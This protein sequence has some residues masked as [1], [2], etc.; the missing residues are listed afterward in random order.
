V[1][2]DSGSRCALCGATHKDRPLD[3][4]HIKPKSKGGKN[5]YEN[6]QVLCA[7]CNRS[8]GNKDDT[9]FRNAKSHPGQDCPFCYE[10]SKGRLEEELD[11]VFAI[12][13]GFPVSDGHLLIILKRHTEDYFPLTEAERFEANQLIQILRK[14]IQQEDSTVTGF[15]I[16]VACSISVESN[17]WCVRNRK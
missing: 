1:L 14:R 3:V 4:D 17:N 16:G 6:L 7:K 12:R 13:D 5:G 9:D 11:S 15:N 8:T 10:N 2:K